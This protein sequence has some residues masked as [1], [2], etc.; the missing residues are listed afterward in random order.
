MKSGFSLTRVIMFKRVLLSMDS[1]SAAME[2]F[3]CI[4]DL[5]IMGMKELVILHVI[6]A[7]LLQGESPDVHKEI[8]RKR[9]EG[10]LRALEKK[11]VSVKLLMPMGHPS[12]VVAQVA[13][14]EEVDL[15]LIGSI[16]ES[17]MREFFLGS[18]VTDVIR[19]STKPVLV[20]KYISLGEK[21]HLLPIFLQKWA[22]VLLPT[23]FSKAA[24]EVYFKFLEVANNIHKITLLHVVEKE[25]HGK[26]PGQQK[27]EAE[28]I[29]EGWKEKFL[30]H[31]ANVDISIVHGVPS[32]QIVNVAESEGATLIALPSRGVGLTSLVLG[33]TAD[34]VMRSSGVPVLLFKQAQDDD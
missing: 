13:E 8:F 29:L 27:E 31:D 4:P 25:R 26:N 11:G 28:R 30:Q 20:E 6:S 21:T 22:S 2:L 9:L 16:G 12:E 10:K 18:T 19:R 5:R 24:D 7:E 34:A 32:Q 33:R 3:N 15:I 23:D 17:V 1:S 14:E